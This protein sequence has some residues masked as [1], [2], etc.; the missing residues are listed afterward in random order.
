MQICYVM[1]CFDAQVRMVLSRKHTICTIQQSFWQM[2]CSG[3]QKASCVPMER[4]WKSSF[5][6]NWAW[7]A[8]CLL[9]AHTKLVPSTNLCKTMW[10]CSVQKRITNSWI[11]HAWLLL[12]YLHSQKQVVVPPKNWF[13]TDIMQPWSCAPSA[14]VMLSMCSTFITV[15]VHAMRC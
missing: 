8:I 12:S 1:I 7:V 6:S 14:M 15:K 11:T 13:L 2:S 4:H 9:K 5:V 3:H 10:P